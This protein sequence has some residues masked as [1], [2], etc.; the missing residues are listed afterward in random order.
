MKKCGCCSIEKDDKEF[1]VQHDKRINLSYLCSRCKTCEKTKALERYHKKR[2]ECIQKNREYKKEHV[3]EIKLKAASY[4][5]ANK[6]KIREKR[7]PYMRNYYLENKDKIHQRINEY[8]KN[9]ITVTLR[10]RLSSRLMDFIIKAKNTESYLGTKIQVVKEWLEFN[11]DENMNWSNYGSYW[12]V[13]HTLPLSLFDMNNDEDVNIAFSWMN[14]MPLEKIK[15]IMKNNRILPL[16][17]CYNEQRLIEFGAKNNIQKNI[18]D[19]LTVYSKYFKKFYEKYLCNTTKL[20]EH[21]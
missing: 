20:R 8:R 9:N 1:R 11:F 15:N 19:Y 7:R 4:F 16:Y 21:P 17:V 5:Q 13:D 14:L 10:H 2:D 12:T 18:D 6:H 3:E